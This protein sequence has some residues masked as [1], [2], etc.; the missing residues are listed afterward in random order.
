MGY[1]IGPRLAAFNFAGGVL[2]W[3]LL[4]PLLTFTDGAIH[5][6]DI[7]RP[8]AGE[9]GDDG[10]WR[11]GDLL[12]VVRPIAVGGMLVGAS[13][14]LFKMRKQLTAGIGQ[15]VSDLKKVRQQRTLRNAPNAIC[16]RRSY[17]RRSRLCSSR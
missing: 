15:A 10:G 16:H 1:I 8:T 17:S 9:L 13:Y 12:L 7:S 14:T 2:A 3:G 6:G 4:V 5:S 11:C